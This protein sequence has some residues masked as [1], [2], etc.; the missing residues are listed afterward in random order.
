MQLLEHLCLEASFLTDP[1]WVITIFVD[2]VARRSFGSHGCS[3]DQLTAGILRR[4]CRELD[5]ASVSEKLLRVR[6]RLDTP[7]GFAEFKYDPSD[8]EF[9]EVPAGEEINP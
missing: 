4:S 3:R 2:E 5:C 1:A 7:D 8:W 9:V 6:A